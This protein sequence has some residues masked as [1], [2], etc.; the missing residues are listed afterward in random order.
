MQKCFCRVNYACAQ[1][2][3]F[4]LGGV[5]R[6]RG[7]LDFGVPNVFSPCSHNVLNLFTQVLQAFN[8]FPKIFSI[9]PH[10]IYNVCP[11]L[12]FYNLHSWAKGKHFYNV[13]AS[14]YLVDC[15]MLQKY[16]AISQSNWLLALISFFEELN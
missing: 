11:K 6:G 7:V 13:S 4:S 14:V 5:G 15:S 9:A 2:V 16:F 10:F 8:L 3:F 12:K 1:F